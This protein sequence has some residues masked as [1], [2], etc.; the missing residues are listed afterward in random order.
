MLTMIVD[1]FYNHYNSRSIHM[2]ALRAKTIQS[3]CRAASPLRMS[4]GTITPEPSLSSA[5]QQVLAARGTRMI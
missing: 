2:A 5:Q 4:A 1:S 3:Y